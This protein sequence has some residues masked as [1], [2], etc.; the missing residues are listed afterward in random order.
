MEFFVGFS[1]GTLASCG[2]KKEVAVEVI[3]EVAPTIEEIPADTTAN[4][5]TATK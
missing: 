2:E 5:A 3:E 1:I 4:D